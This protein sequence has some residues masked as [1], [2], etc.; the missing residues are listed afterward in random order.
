M[1]LKKVETEGKGYQIGIFRVQEPEPTWI[2][3]GDILP[4]MY[5]KQDMFAV[6]SLNGTKVCFITVPRDNQPA[7]DCFCFEFEVST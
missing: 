5:V 3:Q 6:S 7:P 4:T 1:I 2:I